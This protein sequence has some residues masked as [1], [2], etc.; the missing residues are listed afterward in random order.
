MQRTITAA[1]YAAAVLKET[2]RLNPISV[3]R[4]T[5]EYTLDLSMSGLHR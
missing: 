5:S 4:V 2:F 1:R 3:G